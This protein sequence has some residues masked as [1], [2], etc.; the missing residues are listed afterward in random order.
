MRQLKEKIAHFAEKNTIVEEKKGG[1][2][3]PDSI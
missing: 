3:V 1:Y 2:K